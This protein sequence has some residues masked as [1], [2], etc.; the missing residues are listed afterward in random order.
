MRDEPRAASELSRCDANNWVVTPSSN[1]F[2]FPSSY[3]SLQCD[4]VRFSW[5]P[6]GRFS[7]DRFLGEE[8][9]WV[10]LFDG[11]LLNKTELFEEYCKYSVEELLV[12]MIAEIG[13]PA[14]L[15]KLRGPF[16]GAF[17]D[18]N[19]KKLYAFGNQTGDTAVYSYAQDGR[20]AVGN[21]LDL[22]ARL[23]SSQDCNLSFNERAA[24][25][26]LTFG[27]MSDETTFFQEIERILPGHMQVLEV[28]RG[29]CESILPYWKLQYLPVD[30]DLADHI[31]CFDRAFRH[32][33]ERCFRKD[34]EYGYV[35]HLADLSAGMDSRMTNVVAQSLG[36][37]NITN[38]SYSQ[39]SSSE[40]RIAEKVAENLGQDLL[41]YPLDGGR[42]I[43]DP[44]AILSL[45]GATSYYAAITGGKNVIERL[46]FDFFGL[47]HTG[48]LGDLIAGTSSKSPEDLPPDPFA[49]RYSGLHNFPDTKGHW[50]HS[51]AE[52][53]VL[54][55]RGF[56]G[57]LGTHSLRRHF[58]PAVSPFIDVDVLEVALSIPLH[59]RYGHRF[60]EEW[61]KECY[62]EATRTKS[63]RV[64][65]SGRKRQKR[66]HSV[67][68]TFDILRGWTNRASIELGFGPIP[69][70]K[71][72]MNP[73]DAW[74]AEN[75]ALR[76]MIQTKAE[77]VESM[78]IS[79]ELKEALSTS[80][81]PRGQMMDHLL[82]VTVVSMWQMYFSETA[83]Q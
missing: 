73:F 61:V 6:D 2:N 72:N 18:R 11:V 43:L 29:H 68:Q 28:C 80:F 65:F 7:Q 67:R 41:Y 27:Y 64:L 32:A 50:Q 76:E 62:P 70:S 39:S 58:T 46:N 59:L 60:Y 10:I 35:R 40:R 30:R 20:W 66:L 74:Y 1:D 69:T 24:R 33:V 55:V 45:S 53:Q 9:K 21:S 5:S 78:R 77:V 14:S 17:F 56:L 52:V 22:L 26:M 71:N 15:S 3:R 81:G 49:Y 16:S 42:C 47:E 54:S 79:H 4:G 63:S 57:T 83:N 12:A 75:A 31:S 19:E 44:E 8:A 37:K 38:I 51:N 23:L 13:V 36:F 25:M 48:Q 82:A 34:E